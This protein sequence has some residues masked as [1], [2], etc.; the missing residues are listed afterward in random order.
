MIE[1]IGWILKGYAATTLSI[2]IIYVLALF[3][4]G[5][6]PDIELKWLIDRLIKIYAWTLRYSRK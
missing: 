4:P 2:V 5:D 1:V 6:H 3:V